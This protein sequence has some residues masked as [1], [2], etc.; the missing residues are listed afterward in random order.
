MVYQGT[1]TPLIRQFLGPRKNR[2]FEEFFWHKLVNWGFKKSKVLFFCYFLTW[3]GVYDTGYDNINNKTTSYIHTLEFNI[4]TGHWVYRLSGH[5]ELI[6][7]TPV[8][9]IETL[10]INTWYNTQRSLDTSFLS[11]LEIQSYFDHHFSWFF[12]FSR[13]KIW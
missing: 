2:L 10:I 13:C 4:N 9:Q 12:N 8:V 6:K 11:F 3:L 5:P 1:G 7:I